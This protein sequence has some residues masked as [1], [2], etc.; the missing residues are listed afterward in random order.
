[1]LQAEGNLYY[2]SA[3]IIGPD[4]TVVGRYHKRHPIQFFA[5]GVPGPGT[6]VFPTPAGRLGVAICYDLDFTDTSLGLARSGAE[7]LVVPTFDAYNWG[8][9]QQLQHARLAL[10]RAAEVR[11]CVVRPT[12]SGVSQI[13]APGGEQ[14]TFLPRGDASLTT[15]VVGLRGDLTPY[16]RWVWLLPYVCLALSTVVLAA[17]LFR[18]TGRAAG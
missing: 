13:I 12:S 9:T 16:V 17:S 6:P 4:G 14:V 11:R 18:R 2:N 1:M 10:A 7:V 8:P 15:G 5:D 3:L